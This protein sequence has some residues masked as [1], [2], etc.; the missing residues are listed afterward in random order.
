MGKKKTKFVSS[1]GSSLLTRIK[2][3]RPG[4]KPGPATSYMPLRVPVATKEKL[5]AEAARKG[6]DLNSYLQ[7]LLAAKA[8][9]RA[10]PDAVEE[11]RG[12]S[13]E[14]EIRREL[15]NSVASAG[16]IRRRLEGL[17]RLCRGLLADAER[18]VREGRYSWWH[19][20]PDPDTAKILAA[21]DLEIANLSK[22]AAEARTAILAT[23][24]GKDPGGKTVWDSIMGEKQ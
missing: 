18:A 8:N 13:A 9:G 10:T 6:V 7:D 15:L 23:R 22:H 24:P 17:R 21:L 20:T 2:G 19:G 11:E 12:H 5:R 4:R 3:H 1:H 14:R 16:D